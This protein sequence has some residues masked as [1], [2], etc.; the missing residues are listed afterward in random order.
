MSEERTHQVREE[1]FCHNCGAKLP[2]AAANFCLRCGAAQ[3]PAA[4]VE[5]PGGPPPQIPQPGSIPTPSVPGV[6]Q[7][8]NVYVNQNVDQ[9]QQQTQQQQQQQQQQPIQS[10]RGYGKGCVVLIAIFF[11]LGLIAAFVQTLA[12]VNGTG[13]QVVLLSVL[14]VGGLVGLAVWSEKK[15]PGSLRRRWDKMRGASTTSPLAGDGEASGAQDPNYNMPSDPFHAEPRGERPG[16]ANGPEGEGEP[17][18]HR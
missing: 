18:P 1:R 12:G 3:N 7:P 13:P 16:E 4:S 9:D 11:V 10:R 5:V 8:I 6:P 14:L 15:N 17:P 2:N